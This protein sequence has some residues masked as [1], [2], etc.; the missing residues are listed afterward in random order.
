MT[1]LDAAASLVLS[2]PADR[3][4]LI[5]IAGAPGSGK[6]TFAVALAAEVGGTVL[7][8]DGF[9]L[10]NDVLVARGLADVKGAPETFD[11][12]GFVEL[13]G[14]LRSEPGTVAAPR[15][16]R[17]IEASVPD[18]IVVTTDH[19]LVVVEGNYLL[20]WPDVAPLLDATIFVHLDDATRLDRL[21]ARHIAFGKTP[22]AARDWAL[23]PD[24]E[25]ARLIAAGAARADLVLELD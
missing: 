23:G 5:G 2:L 15:F 22:E 25:N 12:A 24:E 4:I 10:P 9:H 1:A 21:I 14:R 7:P 18:A 17:A 3:R 20:H 11:R 6:S 19:R 16:E 8:M 13:L